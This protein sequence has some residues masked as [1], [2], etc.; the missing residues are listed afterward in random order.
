MADRH[1]RYDD[2]AVRLEP[3]PGGGYLARILHSVAG[4]GTRAFDLPARPTDIDELMATLGGWLR[5]NGPGRDLRPPAPGGRVETNTGAVPVDPEALG[6]ALFDAVLG[7]RLGEAWAY[8]LGT[9]AGEKDRGLRLRLVFDPATLAS[10]PLATLPWELVYQDRARGYLARSRRTPLVRYLDVEHPTVLEPIGSALRVLVV[11]ASPDGYPPLRLADEEARIREAW[12]ASPGVELM[13][14]RECDLETLRGLLLRE[15]AFTSSTSWAMASSP[16]PVP[17]GRR[18][19]SCS[20]ERVGGPS[21]RRP[22]RSPRPCGGSRNFA[23][24]CST[25]ASRVGFPRSRGVDP[26][27]GVAAALIL[28]GLPAAIAMQFPISDRAA[29]VFGGGLTRALA[30]GDPV[31]AAVAEGRIAIALDDRGSLEWA[32]PVLLSRLATGAVLES[33]GAGPAPSALQARLLDFSGLVEDKS[34]EFVG[35]RFVFDAIE[36]FRRSAGRGYFQVVAEP[37]IGKSAMVAELVRRHGWVHHFNHRVT[38]VIRPEA[39]LSNVCAQLIL[40]HRL[41]I[42][43]LPPEAIRDGNFFSRVL[44]Q[45]SGRLDPGATTVILIDALDESSRDGLERGVN[46]LYLPPS[47]PAGIVVVLTTRPEAP[48]RSPRIDGPAEALELDPEGPRNLADVR[49]YVETFLPWPGIRDYLSAQGLSEAAFAE[50][51][52]DKSEGNFMYLHY[53]LP[54]I[55]GGLYRGRPLD[56]IPAGLADYYEANFARM[57]RRDR[58]IWLG[59]T[60]PVLGAL[61]VARDALPFELLHAFSGV[62]DGRRVREALRDLRPFLAVSQRKTAAGPLEVYRFYHET[63]YEF[64]RDHEAVAIDLRAAH[65]RVVEAY[66]DGKLEGVEGLDDLE[67]LVGSD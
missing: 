36:E 63:F 27:S 20:R 42:P 41:E 47:L 29:I 40:A 43:D 34:R 39:F 31:E 35:R 8:H 56:E 9:L 61:A 1:L 10:T 51:M 54:A 19:A 57:E 5:A 15:A 33:A 12:E 62:E 25:P 7:G 67:H 50:L 32:T 49:E 37:G 23:S 13:L 59:E 60:L 58:E 4:G 14:V 17:D 66:L 52:T 22:R 2:F 44:E 28:A 16:S 48:E 46:P 11:A 6:H 24:S 21:R 26:Y 30:K 38:N 3:A 53:V 64:I 45:V 55:D 65:R 18:A